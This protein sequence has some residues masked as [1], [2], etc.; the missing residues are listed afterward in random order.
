VAL[1]STLKLGDW[2]E[3][4]DQTLANDVERF[5]GQLAVEIVEK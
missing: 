1:P 4:R 2:R 3:D 5:A